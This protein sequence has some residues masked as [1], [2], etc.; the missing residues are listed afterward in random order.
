MHTKKT[1]EYNLSIDTLFIH[2]YYKMQHIFQKSLVRT[3]FHLSIED[4]APQISADMNILVIIYD[5]DYKLCNMTNISTKFGHMF[6]GI[7][8]KVCSQW[9]FA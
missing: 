5:V 4:G 3:P 6:A 2:T 9:C 8:C 1:I 7:H